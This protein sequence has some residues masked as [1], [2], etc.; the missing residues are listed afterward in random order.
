MNL[1]FSNHR[2]ARIRAFSCAVFCLVDAAL[3]A[4]S[5][6]A[7]QPTPPQF[8]KLA[9]PPMAVEK[10]DD[11][12]VGTTFGKPAGEGPFA[13]VILLQTCDGATVDQRDWGRRA[14]EHGYVAMVV[15]SMGPRGVTSQNCSLPAFVRSR[16]ALDAR[17]HLEQFAFV[18]KT[19][20]AVIGFSAGAA[21]ARGVADAAISG[22]QS[23]TPFRAV[24]EF[25]PFCVA[26]ASAGGLV[27]LYENTKRNAPEL[28]LLGDKDPQADATECVPQYESLK[29]AGADID[30]VVY[31]GA[32]HC[33]DCKSSDGKEARDDTHRKPMPFRYNAAATADAEQKVFAFLAE[34]MK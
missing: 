14:M 30:W 12:K 6:F 8:P 24:V 10:A 13:A 29:A 7:Q 16:D 28:I 9:F 31:K 19:R 26:R 32:T 17:A 18:D 3:A 4:G 34:K 33:F 11:L 1:I 21:G 5:A 27:K 15:D 20:I 25:Y 23:F 22:A 2:A